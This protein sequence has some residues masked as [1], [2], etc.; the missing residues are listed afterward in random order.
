LSGVKEIQL[1]VRHQPVYNA[2]LRYIR[3][4][5]DKWRFLLRS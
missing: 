3:A 1:A 2:A 5:L 4:I